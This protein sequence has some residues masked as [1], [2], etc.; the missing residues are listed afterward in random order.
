MS[1]REDGRKVA[2]FSGSFGGIGWA[3]VN[4]FARYQLIVLDREFTLLLAFALLV[5]AE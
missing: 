5:R 1:G 2:V 3:G 4:H